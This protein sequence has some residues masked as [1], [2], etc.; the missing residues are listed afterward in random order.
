MAPGMG[1][2]ILLG[3]SLWFAQSLWGFCAKKRM[4]REKSPWM[5]LDEPLRLDKPQHA[6]G[7]DGGAARLRGCSTAL[8]P[9]NI[10]LSHQQQLVGMGV[11]ARGG[12]GLQASAGWGTESALDV[13][14]IVRSNVRTLRNTRIVAR[15]KGVCRTRWDATGRRLLADAVSVSELNGTLPRPVHSV[16]TDALFL[17]VA[18]TVYD[19][20][21]AVDLDPMPPSFHSVG[22]SI[23]YSLQCTLIFQE[24][25]NLLKSGLEVEAPV[26]V[27][28]PTAPQLK[29][30]REPGNLTHHTDPAQNE[31]RIIYSIS[32]QRRVLLTLT[33]LC[34][35]NGSNT[36]GKGV[37]AK[38]HRSISATSESFKPPV[39]V[40]RRAGNPIESIFRRFYLYVDPQHADGCFESP[41]ISVKTA[42]R[43]D[44]V[45]TGLSNSANVSIDIPVIIV[46]LTAEQAALRSSQQHKHQLHHLAQRT[47]VD[48]GFELLAPPPSTQ[49][50]MSSTSSFTHSA[51]SP[52]VT[53]TATPHASH[54]MMTPPETPLHTT[55]S[56]N[57]PTPAFANHPA[58]ANHQLS[59]QL[60]TTNNHQNRHQR[61]K[62]NLGSAVSTSNIHNRIE[63]LSLHSGPS[64][65]ALSA[66][67]SPFSSKSSLDLLETREVRIP[68]G[69]ADF[70]TGFL[71]HGD[72]PVQ[73]AGDA[74][75]QSL[76]AS[77]SQQRPMSVNMS[78]A[79]TSIL[80]YYSASG[81]GGATP[82]PEWSAEM[83]AE[84]AKGLGAG[85]EVA[86]M[87]VEQQVDGIVLMGLSGEDLRK[88]LNVNT[89]G[90][91]HKILAGIAAMRKQ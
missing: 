31:S 10:A 72:F 14:L 64:I 25:M 81:G 8:Q 65:S 52:V 46:P 37:Q 41:L 53:T 79:G 36:S 85:Q 84:W 40:T 39:A 77:S 55:F 7:S 26:H 28:I 18:R 11:N 6:S 19:S 1:G 20:R 34:L 9:P 21:E 58:S 44:I 43:L 66:P 38:L 83:V 76:E 30:L 63:V 75:V 80:G 60:L 50:I 57:K 90:L 89:L 15:L 61:S 82:A 88:E 13:A 27:F 71:R 16:A 73:H 2:C 69:G 47:H 29:L 70:S 12:G 68:F 32:M 3:S 33:Y 86:D 54:L 23:F 62:D 87:F 48:S 42:F 78:Y 56:E 22:G 74:V 67:A 51:P 35:S 5:T 91:R 4:P 24:G 45:P 49:I 59:P 17:D